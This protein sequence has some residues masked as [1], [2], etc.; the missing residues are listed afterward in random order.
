MPAEHEAARWSALQGLIDGALDLPEKARAAYLERACGDDGELLA[1]AM[2]LL[3]SCER[4]DAADGFLAGSAVAFAAPFV[5]ELATE[6]A[7]REAE[8]HTRFA[9]ALHAT[10]DGRYTIE[11]ELGR[12]GMAAVYAARDGRHERRVAVKVL[13]ASVTHA[14]AARFLREVRTAAALTHPHIVGVHDSGEADGFLY[15]VMPFVTGET[16][17][18]RLLRDGAM[19]VENAVRLL[20]DVADALGYAHSRGLVHRDLKPANVLMSEGHALVADFGIAKAL[21]V[22][23]PDEAAVNADGSCDLRADLTFAGTT[24]GTPAYMAPEQ[25]GGGAADA[26][27]DL[28]ALGLV[29]Y[30]ALTGAHPFGTR[31][32][33]EML[34]AQRSEVPPPLETRRRDVPSDLAA[35]VARLLAKDPSARPQSAGEVLGI[36]NDVLR[37]SSFSRPASLGRART[38]AAV[39]V[40]LLAAAGYATWRSL[41]PGAAPAG[42]VTA[43]RTVAV[44]PFADAPGSA[45][46]QYF[47][48][49]ITDELALAL[50]RL[51]G[52]RVTGRTSS[53]AFSGRSPTA[54]EI[55]EALNVDAFVTGSVR[56]ASD[57]LRVAVQL[58]STGDGSVLWGDVYEARSSDMFAVQDELTRAIVAA[59]AP[60]LGDADSDLAALDSRRGTADQE[61]YD[62]F[63]RARYRW[64]ERGADN[65]EHA[66]RF[67]NAAIARDPSFAR[68]HAGL[69]L[70]YGVLPIYVK[71]SAEP[72][73]TLHLKSAERAMLLDSTLADAQVALASANELQL[74][75]ADAEARYRAALALE[76]DN[77]TTHQWFGFFLLNTGRPD[78]AIAELNRAAQL[79]PLARSP[80]A[81]VAM[82]Y[83]AARRFTEA[84][85]AARRVL[86]YDS[87]FSL[88]LLGLGLAQTFGGKPDSG[89]ATLEHA[90]RLY[91]GTLGVR[92]ALTFAYAAADRWA[93]AERMRAYLHSGAG[94]ATEVDVAFADLVFGDPEPAIRLMATERGR[95]E[96]Y[97][98]FGFGCHPFLD[99]LE[100]DARFQD[101]LLDLG[102]QHCRYAR[103]WPLRYPD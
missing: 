68:A 99:P 100:N 4:A 74:R 82:G 93:D 101:V 80:G 103:P 25:I 95:R 31:D 9:Q 55:R 26:R 62:L 50:T 81:T 17:Q 32:S 64:Q 38:I 83:L 39:I 28:Y 27:S 85:A 58:V 43:V 3:R 97:N 7:A 48:G 56:R 22:A 53:Y 75:F 2:R 77:V 86:A 47:S 52:L 35:L 11:R 42:R 63:L 33:H 59:L 6:Q 10:S 24:P 67:F 40:V 1:D 90:L 60:S 66:I 61:A 15:Y 73:L 72:A 49:G 18:A 29:M 21:A 70:T 79:D 84:E 71:E 23:E 65:L 12:G 57:R 14:G 94:G 37:V 89:V 16:L 5:A 36:A 44:L 87:T 8:R 88:A 41:S 91:P 13:E 45:D 76:P 78:E 69:A 20:R 34:L 96:W 92:T 30:E 46:D 98:A 102:V 51:P 54:G 19:P